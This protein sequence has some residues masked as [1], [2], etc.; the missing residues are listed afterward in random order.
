MPNG[1]LSGSGKSDG[2][3]RAAPRR[4]SCAG[5]QNNN[6]QI[7]TFYLYTSVSIALPT[8]MRATGFALEAR[9]PMSNP[10]A[11]LAS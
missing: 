5:G 3:R 9:A 1:C 11:S 2:P 7:Y 6:M 8:P 10:S 4:G